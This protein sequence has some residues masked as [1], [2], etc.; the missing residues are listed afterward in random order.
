MLVPAFVAFQVGEGSQRL[1][2][3][4][5]VADAL[6]ERERLLRN[7]VRA[8]GLTHVLVRDR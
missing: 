8:L 6:G 5:P 7:R 1:A 3:E 4:Y 2:F